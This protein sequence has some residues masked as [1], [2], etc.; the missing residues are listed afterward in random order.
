MI[1]AGWLGLVVGVWLTGVDEI[2]AVGG[3]RNVKDVG[4]AVVGTGEIVG[5]AGKGCVAD[6]ET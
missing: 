3:G 4:V 5:V 6:G 1:S 2:L